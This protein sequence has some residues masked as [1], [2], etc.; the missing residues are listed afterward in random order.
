MK[1]IGRFV[2]IALVAWACQPQ[3]AEQAATKRDQDSLDT[4]KR[5]AWGLHDEL[6]GLQGITAARSDSLW[7]YVLK[8]ERIYDLGKG[9]TLAVKPM[10]L[11][12]TAGLKL[13]EEP[14]WGRLSF[15]ES[16]VYKSLPPSIRYRSFS[17]RLE[18]YFDSSLFAFLPVDSLIE[19]TTKESGEIADSLIAEH[20]FRPIDY[21]PGQYLVIH[22]SQY[23][24]FYLAL[25]SLTGDQFIFLPEQGYF[26][27]A[28]SS[29]C[30]FHN[31]GEGAPKPHLTIMDASSTDRASFDID[32][33]SGSR[34]FPQVFRINETSFIVLVRCITEAGCKHGLYRFDIK[35]PFWH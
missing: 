22:A 24:G 18:I 28:N 26:R 2:L 12:D 5:S 10:S 23:E 8:G 6:K 3:G 11:S 20:S 19:A 14:A 17:D 32:L 15:K 29:L 9:A 30:L 35:F 16:P 21:I 4:T 13:Q 31:S 1:A 25:V 34:G 7:R 33:E 27:I